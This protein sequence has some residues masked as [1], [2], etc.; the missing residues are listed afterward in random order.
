MGP[1]RSVGRQLK[2]WL[3]SQAFDV[4]AG[5]ALANR[6]IDALGDDEALRGPLRDLASQPLFR[7]LLL[8]NGSGQRATLDELNKRLT[9]TYTPAVLQ[10]LQALLEEATGLPLLATEAPP[11]ATKARVKADGGLADAIGLGVDAGVG[12][13][14]VASPSPNQPDATA[15]AARNRAGKTTAQ[16]ISNLVALL[17]ELRAISPGI[18]LGAGSSLVLW[19]AA[20]RLE[21]MLPGEPQGGGGL[22][23][24]LALLLLQAL[25]LGPLRGIQRQWPLDSSSACDPSHAWRWV[26]APWI[27][28]RNGEGL[29]LAAALL[30]LVSSAP[31]NLPLLALR[32]LD[33]PAVALGYG[34]IALITTAPGVLVA[35]R[36][37]IQK[38]WSGAAGVVAALVSLAALEGLIH[39]E[40]VHLGAPPVLMPA[41]VLLLL[42]SAL[43]LQLELPPQTR[44]SSRPWQRLLASSWC[45]GTLLGLG[46]GLIDGLCALL[47]S[48]ATLIH[49]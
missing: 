18:A 31:A 3:H 11:A 6:L 29:A 7:K 1:G 32:P 25:A 34:L 33:L 19:W 16:L 39:R 47:R 20:G 43:A 23:L 5:S 8:Q 30:L 49:P 36:Y 27:H 14:G 12:V 10:E 37:R 2:A 35:R 46:A 45:W 15:R 24:V 13:G 28:Q 40:V 38:R 44:E 17:Q 22:L 21:D 9:A 48:L 26:L 41:W 4:T 42:I